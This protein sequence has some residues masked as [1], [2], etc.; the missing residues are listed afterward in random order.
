MMSP[1]SKRVARSSTVCCT[2][3]AGTIIHATRGLFSFAE[4]SSRDRAAMAP[5][6]ASCSTAA[7]F[8]SYTTHS[9]PPRSSRRTILA[10]M[11]P[12]PIM[13]ICITR[14]YKVPEVFGGQGCQ[15][16]K[17]KDLSED[18]A[19]GSTL[20]ASLLGGEVEIEGRDWLTRVRTA[21]PASG[22]RI[23]ERHRD[24]ASGLTILRY[25]GRRRNDG[26]RCFHALVSGDEHMKRGRVGLREDHAGTIADGFARRGRLETR[27]DD[28][29]LTQDDRVRRRQLHFD[30]LVGLE[31]TARQHL[32]ADRRE[33]DHERRF[34]VQLHFERLAERMSVRATRGREC[35]GC[36][37][38]RPT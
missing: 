2:F 3:A 6:F 26:R 36:R 29:R 25:R 20:V 17:K 7:A 1:R 11:R 23:G 22:S 21:A 34:V 12:R 15:G 30:R 5:S 10:P 14:S 35:A 13:P 8:T 9:W 27:P 37:G 28:L 19:G 32:G 33:V 31:R 16:S 38:L 4:N 24:E 18:S